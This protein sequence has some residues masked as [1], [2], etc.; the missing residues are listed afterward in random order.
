VQETGAEV[1]CFIFRFC[2]K[3]DGF[4]CETAR[5][6]GAVTLLRGTELAGIGLQA[7]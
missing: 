7:Q 4:R 5:V 3:R 2:M 1:P 6:R